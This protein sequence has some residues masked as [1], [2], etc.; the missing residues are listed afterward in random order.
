MSGKNRIKGIAELVP[1]RLFKALGDPN[2]VALLAML[3]DC[4][5]PCSVSEL[6][7]CC[8][9]D[10]STAS[11]HLS[12]LRDAGALSS[13]RRGKQV[14]YAVNAKS[15]AGTLRRLADALEECCSCGCDN[16]EC[17]DEQE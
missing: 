13:E 9:I 15:L 7:T 5:R 16:K 6:S 3:A 1:S 2:R 8:P 17:C 4:R 11:R 12:A 10:L 14:F